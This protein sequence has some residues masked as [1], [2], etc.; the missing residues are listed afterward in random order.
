MSIYRHQDSLSTILSPLSCT[1]LSDN[2]LD[3]VEVGLPLSSSCDFDQAEAF[4][5]LGELV[6][7]RAAHADFAGEPL[8][9][10]KAVVVVP[11]VL[12]ELGVGDLGAETELRIVEDEIGDLRK[13]APHHGVVRVESYVALAED[14]ADVPGRSVRSHHVLIVACSGSA[15]GRVIPFPIVVVVIVRRCLHWVIG[16]HF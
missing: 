14:I 8:L 9:A 3:L 1:L 2:E 16:V 10:R 13:A 15:H 7:A 5:L 4:Q 12:Q 6:D 11:S